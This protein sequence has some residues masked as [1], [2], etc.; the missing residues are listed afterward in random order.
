MTRRKLGFLVAVVTSFGMTAC[1]DPD[2]PTA[3][4]RDGGSD[5]PD[6]SF[7]MLPP[8][9]ASAVPEMVIDTAFA[10]FYVPRLR[11]VG[12]TFYFQRAD[13][14]HATTFPDGADRRVV[15]G[16]AV[17]S[18]GTDGGLT[19]VSFADFWVDS[20]SITGVLGEA[21]YSA[22]TEGGPL[23][24]TVGNLPASSDDALLMILEKGA[25]ARSGDDLYHATADT[26]RWPGYSLR[27]ASRFGGVWAEVLPSETLGPTNIQIDDRFLYYFGARP[28]PNAGAQALF[29]LPLEQGTPIEDAVAFQSPHFSGFDGN[30]YV[31]EEGLGGG[32][33]WRVRPDATREKVRLPPGVLV[34]TPKTSEYP[35][36]RQGAVYHGSL[37][38]AL[39]ALYQLPDDRRRTERYVVVRIDAGGD[40][41]EA[42]R[43]LPELPID[44][45]VPRDEFTTTLNDLVATEDG[46]FVSVGRRGTR[47]SVRDRTHLFRVMP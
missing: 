36:L 46:V 7:P 27:R 10:G 23:R 37:Y 20:T 44:P 35:Q 14:I 15:L 13:G 4:P 33:L 22:P 26:E 24:V 28:M 12:D 34:R 38:L 5:T 11:T 9:C 39:E 41:A 1:S 16:P 45:E 30:L 17:P 6:A 29:R 42:V 19:N 8:E 32:T 3:P 25:Y 18:V 43:C 31:S 40:K 2:A 21:I 47:N